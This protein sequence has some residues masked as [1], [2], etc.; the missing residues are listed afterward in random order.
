MVPFR[1]IRRE[2]TQ[3]HPDSPNVYAFMTRLLVLLAVLPVAACDIQ[4]SDKGVSV[5]IAEGKAADTW[6]RQYQLPAGGQL[7]VV[8][9]NGAILAVAADGPQVEVDATREVRTHSTEAS[10]EALKKL[11]ITEEVAPGRVRIEAKGDREGGDFGRGVNATVEFRVALPAGL[12]VTLRT[13]H[14][15]VRLE[16][17][18]GTITASSTTGGIT[19]QRVSGA[20]TATTV[21]GGIQMTLAS[22]TGDV[23]LSTVNGGIRLEVPA[24]TNALLEAKAVNGG[25]TVDERLPLTNA[26]RA[27]LHVT[28][29][30][31]AGGP[32][33]SAQ[34]TNGGVRVSAAA[35]P[36]APPS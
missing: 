26:S 12:R 11:E 17:V 15:G 28:G 22:V 30:M 21:N 9:V 24:D 34:T 2:K 7:E 19:G 3:N 8:N 33:I 32:R 1:Q 25:V 16:N 20:L 29:Q 35:S 13:E 18:E 36:D 4:V 14:G 27:R 5:D 10:R 23:Q 31:N 6:S